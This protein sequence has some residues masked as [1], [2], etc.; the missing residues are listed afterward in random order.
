MAIAFGQY[1]V[2]SA[3][4]LIVLKFHSNRPPDL[5][6]VILIG[7]CDMTARS[8]SS[9]ILSLLP[10][11]VRIASRHLRADRIVLLKLALHDDSAYLG[12]VV[13]DH[14]LWIGRARIVW[15]RLAVLRIL[16]SIHTSSGLYCLWGVNDEL[17]V[18]VCKLTPLTWLC[19][20]SNVAGSHTN[21]ILNAAKPPGRYAFASSKQYVSS[22]GKL[23]WARDMPVF[24]VA[25]GVA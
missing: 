21:R 11:R 16:V 24:P 19:A 8:L 1:L 25:C 5:I 18:R 15:A 17:H 7:R 23:C 4:F 22:V 14:G 9:G 12:L 3:Q 10:I 13:F 2:R 20:T 6:H